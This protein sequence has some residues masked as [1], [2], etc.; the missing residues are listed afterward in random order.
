M[1]VNIVTCINSL[2]FYIQFF[3]IMI[4]TFGIFM[5]DAVHVKTW[6]CRQQ[7]VAV[8]PVDGVLLLFFLHTENIPFVGMFSC[9]YGLI[10]IWKVSACMS[11][12]RS[13]L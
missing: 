7:N 9:C 6:G 1:L 5:Q 12:C 13:W 2:H 11:F 3:T 10:H 4:Y 8:A